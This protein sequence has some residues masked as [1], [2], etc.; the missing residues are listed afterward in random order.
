MLCVLIVEGMY[1]VVNVMLSPMSVMSPHHALCNLSTHTV[2]KLCTLSVFGFLNYDVSCM[3]VVNK[4]FVLIPFMLSCSM[5]RFLSLLLLGPCGVSVVM[6]SSLVCL[7]GCRGT[8]CGYCDC[9]ACTV[10]CVA[11]V[12]AERV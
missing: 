12:D 9:D 6:W 11:C 10:V 3:C 4:Q 8:I 5:M 2:L 1:V 7:L